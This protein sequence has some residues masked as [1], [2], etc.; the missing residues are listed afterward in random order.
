[1]AAENFF[2]NNYVLTDILEKE[3][4]QE[5]KNLGNKIDLLC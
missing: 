1:M 4:S 3:K 5:F 2:E